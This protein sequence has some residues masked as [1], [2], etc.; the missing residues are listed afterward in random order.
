MALVGTAAVTHEVATVSI[1]S[2]RASSTRVSG[3]HALAPENFRC[4]VEY[5]HTLAIVVPLDDAGG[6]AVVQ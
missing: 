2:E 5:R 6:D 3:A 4:G 1:V